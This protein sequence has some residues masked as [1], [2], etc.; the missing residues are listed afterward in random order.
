MVVLF[1]ARDSPQA[2]PRGGFAVP[3]LAYMPWRA[4]LGE[5]LGGQDAAG[6]E[7]ASA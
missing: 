6:A 2:F 3:A 4:R 5:G 7:P 1:A